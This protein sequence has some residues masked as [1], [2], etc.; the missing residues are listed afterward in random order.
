MVYRDWYSLFLLKYVSKVVCCMWERV[1]CSRPLFE[2]IVTKEEIA[3]NKQFL[4]LPQ[5]FPLK[6]H[7]IIK[8]FYFLPKYVQSRLLQNCPMR[9]R[10]KVQF[11]LMASW[12]NSSH[13]VEGYR[14]HF[15]KWKMSREDLIFFRKNCILL[16]LK[17][18][19][20]CIT[21]LWHYF[22]PFPSY[23]NSA[24]DDFEHILSKYR[25]SL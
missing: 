14:D 21:M 12:H 4:H 5:C 20:F 16:F 3:Q 8:I 13:W 15:E 17:L 24:A 6:V 25:K 23:D 7:S 1:N 19:M 10:V 18:S 22:K 2:N 9:E 11:L